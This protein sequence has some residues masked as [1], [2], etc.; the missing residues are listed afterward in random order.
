MSPPSTGGPGGMEGL[1]S[2]WG[3]AQPGIEAEAGNAE[4]ALIN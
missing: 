3:S 1:P 4:E 2:L